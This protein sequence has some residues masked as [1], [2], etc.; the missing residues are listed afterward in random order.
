MFKRKLL[1]VI[2]GNIGAGKS[3]LLAALK[4]KMKNDK[5]V[6]FVNEPVEQ[7]SYAVVHGNKYNPLKSFYEQP[8]RFAFSTQLWILE[9]YK[10]QLEELARISTERTVIIMDRGIYSTNIFIRSAHERGLINDFERDFL[11]QAT[12]DVIKQFFGIGKEEKFGADKLYYLDTPFRKCLER[13]RER[14]RLEEKNMRDTHIL[15][16]S[17]SEFYTSYV[18]DFGRTEGRNQVE[19]FYDEN[20]NEI[21]ANFLRF[22]ERFET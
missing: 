4:E 1:L 12:R 19:V 21:V 6:L 13:I 11:L 18:K 10:K 8:H 2:E 15:L 3:F 5:T 14:N 17:I 9:C 20:I 7:F 16:Q 22:L